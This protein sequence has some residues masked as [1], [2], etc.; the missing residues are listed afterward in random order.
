MLMAI[1]PITKLWEAIKLISAKTVHPALMS[2]ITL[3]F[4]IPQNQFDVTFDITK[5]DICTCI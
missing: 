2:M 3:L 1:S 5:H 4:L